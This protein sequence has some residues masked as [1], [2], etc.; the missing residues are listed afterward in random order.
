MARRYP[1]ELIGYDQADRKPGSVVLVVGCRCGGSMSKPQRRLPALPRRERRLR[2]PAQRHQPQVAGS[3]C[4][5]FRPGSN[6]SQRCRKNRLR[7]IACASAPNRTVPGAAK[8]K[9]L[10]QS[11]FRFRIRAAPPCGHKLPSYMSED[12]AGAAPTRI[13]RGSDE[14]LR[15]FGG[16]P[17]GAAK[18]P[19]DLPKSKE[20]KPW[21][22]SSASI[23]APPIP[24]LP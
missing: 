4:I 10:R 12:A 9:C 14:R 6:A 24:A 17:P 23:S 13:P 7:S 20:D 3:D 16:V 18:G 5:S 2:D 1:F 8:R 11:W 19:A 21:A 15:R 22:R